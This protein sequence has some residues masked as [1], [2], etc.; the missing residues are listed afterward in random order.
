MA[1]RITVAD[2]T[3]DWDWATLRNV[4]AIAVERETGWSV[5]EWQRELA[6]DSAI[7]FTA[8]VWIV[9]RRDS[10]ALRFEDVDFVIGDV[11]VEQVGRPDDPEDD[12]DPKESTGSSP[13]S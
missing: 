6:R 4:D 13:E 1:I 2:K 5:L 11:D 9:Q 7:A 10:P 8:L 12:G 3:Y